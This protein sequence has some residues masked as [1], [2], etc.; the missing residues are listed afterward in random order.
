MAKKRVS[1]S[2]KK[3]YLKRN[4]RRTIRH[5]YRRKDKRK[6]KK[7][8][9]KNKRGGSRINHVAPHL[10]ELPVFAKEAK[11][12]VEILEQEL[13]T[14]EIK[15]LFDDSRSVNVLETLYG[16]DP[17][18]VGRI[19][20][21]YNSKV[22]D[23]T[24]EIWSG[25]GEIDATEHQQKL[26]EYD[27][28]IAPILQKFPSGHPTYILISGHSSMI[29]C[30]E[31]TRDPCFTL[32][33]R[34]YKLILATATSEVLSSSKR[35]MG[36]GYEQNESSYYRMYEGLIP[37]QG[38]NFNLVYRDEK[39]KLLRE[40]NTW[41]VSWNVSKRLPGVN[42]TGVRAP[43]SR[44]YHGRGQEEKILDYYVNFKID[45][46]SS[47]MIQ[48]PFA[49]ARKVN[50]K[51]AS[52]E[53]IETYANAMVGEILPLPETPIE[54]YMDL[55]SIMPIDKI[56]EQ[57]KNSVTPGYSGNFD[58]FKLSQLL[59]HIEE[60]G[61]TN[62]NVP[63]VIVG[64]FCRSGEFNYNIDGL[65]NHC[66]K[67]GLKP[68]MKEYFMGDISYEGVSDE[69]RRGISLASK[70]K[71][72]DFWGIYENL[73]SNLSMFATIIQQRFKTVRKKIEVD[74]VQMENGVYKGINLTLS[75]VCLIFQMDQH[76]QIK[77]R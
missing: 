12:K 41:D 27:T 77:S 7:T 11:G 67:F 63:K 70:T 57:I 55:Y 32:L 18:E 54:E 40:E 31:S 25:T 44:T 69:L 50:N 15:N 5:T 37:N 33:P 19:I 10:L 34:G 53:E 2:R 4:S 29:D 28:R 47:E 75:D 21:E 23:L 16:G 58:R 20:E 62:V 13:G 45:E 26:D 3:S 46:R 30:I 22:S 36:E 51:E 1:K 72:Q 35:L 74:S 43:Y 73:K 24:R 65:I 60:A 66:K 71:P 56:K 17:E 14:S 64:T 9:K 42:I 38:I 6:I 8:R 59:K 61:K 76:L 48:I 49:D 52:T 39:G 68:L